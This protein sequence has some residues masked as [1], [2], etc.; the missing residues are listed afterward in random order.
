MS[1]IL[2]FR[3]NTAPAVDAIVEISVRRE[4]SLAGRDDI[5]TL[6]SGEE[7]V[8]YHWGVAVALATWPLCLGASAIWLAL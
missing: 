8:E 1:K 4:D 6:H 2:Q 7:T 5:Q 3:T